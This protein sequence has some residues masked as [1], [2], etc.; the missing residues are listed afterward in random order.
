M[1][2]KNPLFITLLMAANLTLFG[3]EQSFSLKQAI[4]YAIENNKKTVNADYE[5]EKANQKVKQ[6]MAIGL[7]QVNAEGSF[8]NFLDIP[9]TVAPAKAFNP[10]AQD[11]DIVEL[12]FGTDY[13]TN[14]TLSVTQLIFDGSYFVGLKTSKK[15]KSVSQLQK[16]KTELE[17]KEGVTKAYYNVLVAQESITILEELLTTNEELVKKAQILFDEGVTEEDN[18][19]QLKL[20]VLNIK[21]TI[22]ASKKRQE[23][24]ETMLKYEMGI[25]LNSSVEVTSSL[26]DI[27]AETSASDVSNENVNNNIDFQLLQTQI[28]LQGL[29]VKY[30]KSRALPSVGAFFNHQRSAFRYEFDFFKD[31]PWYPT[32][33]WGFQVSI[34]IW[35]G[36]QQK[37]LVTQAKLDLMQSENQLEMLEDGL[38]L[39]VRNAKTN[40]QNSLDAY[41]LQ[42]DAIETSK[43]IYDRHQL[44][45]GEGVIS[46]LELTQTQ[47]QY[48]NAQ[49]TFISSIFELINAK[50]ELD[51]ITNNL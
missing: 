4:D 21:N 17:I 8:Q 28:E 16:K 3:Q 27:V 41:Q 24:A 50:I 12:Q 15:F 30:E 19:D 51:K 29:N 39:Q 9:T 7:P 45:F 25:D 34:P 33:I 40:F 13:N 6:T 14:A 42:K 22:A 35:S 11:G 23:L 5:I 43:K 20:A 32:T 1:I 18:L 37:A 10:L 48:I 38:K 44:K 36:G 31:K 47:N 2:Q 26:N 46:S 49:S